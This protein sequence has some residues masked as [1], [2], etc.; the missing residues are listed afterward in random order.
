MSEIKRGVPQGSILGPLLFNVFI[1]DLFMFIENC[2]IC[3]FADD[4][5][6]YSGGIELSIILENLKHDMKSILKWFK[7]NSMKAN[8]EKFQF[9]ILGRKNR[10][11]ITLMINSK[12]IQEKDSVELLG[13][14]IDKKLTFNEHINNLCRNANYKLYALRR[15]RKYL[16]RD[17]AKLLYSAFIN[18]QF[19]YASTIWM[20]CRKNKYSK[21]QKI[22]HKSLKVVFNRDEEY[23]S[24]LE[25]NNEISIHQ[26]HLHALICEVFKSLNNT[27]PEFM[28]SYFIFKNTTYNI[29]NGPLMILTGAKST[30]Y[31][32]N[33]VQFRACLLWN[34][35]TRSIKHSES[36]PELKRKLKELGNIDCNCI[37][38]R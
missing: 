22:H 28:W 9:M 13:I 14:R 33:S 26:K 10:S 15:I 30:Y 8:P 35:L 23:L 34:G 20:F 2:E 25:I 38:C 21:I 3:N 37:L 7:V 6:L 27:N 17:Q 1:S 36:V 29:K 5:T 18:S 4:N 31:G 24:L 19:S 11:K 12:E 32:I 16:T